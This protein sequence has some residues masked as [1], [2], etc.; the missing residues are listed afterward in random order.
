[1][2]S[3]LRPHRRPGKSSWNG[4]MATWVPCTASFRKL[5]LAVAWQDVGPA[6]TWKKFGLA[7]WGVAGQHPEED[8]HRIWFESATK[9][10]HCRGPM[11]LDDTSQ[12]C[13]GMFWIS[14]VTSYPS[15]EADASCCGGEEG[16][17]TWTY[18][19]VGSVWISVSASAIAPC[20]CE[21]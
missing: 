11:T 17:C 16:K 4:F 19:A 8:G 12:Q 14:L 10:A 3:T 6:L 18:E 21:R 15:W 5:G 9:A 1:M 2:R 13:E 20:A 7:G